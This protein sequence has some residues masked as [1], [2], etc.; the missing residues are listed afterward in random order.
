LAVVVLLSSC[1]SGNFSSTGSKEQPKGAEVSKPVPEPTGPIYLVSTA[2]GIMGHGLQGS[3]VQDSAPS[4]R[5]Q[6]QRTRQLEA[7][8][9]NIKGE[10]KVV[11]MF[12]YDGL[13]PLAVSICEASTS[14]LE[15]NNPSIPICSNNS[16]SGFIGVGY[17][18][19]NG[20]FCGKALRGVQIIKAIMPRPID[21]GSQN[22][23][24]IIVVTPHRGS[25]L[26]ASEFVG[27]MTGR[28]GAPLPKIS[29]VYPRAK[30]CQ[31]NLNP[32]PSDTVFS[33]P[34]GKAASALISPFEDIATETGG[35]TLDLCT[36]SV[37]SLL[38]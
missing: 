19:S 33:I 15:T 8:K 24:H 9:A 21:F 13:L 14:K 11:S 32:A 12:S 31:T 22:P 30:A 5:Y 23:S 38:D 6:T 37:S 36:E 16:K 7:Y 29:F 2:S 10:A 4:E 20:I 3:C 28:F 1:S 35:E 34:E 25:V 26:S 18:S 17:V 27:M